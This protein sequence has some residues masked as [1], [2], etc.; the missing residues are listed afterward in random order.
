VS[1][2]TRDP[3]GAV[4]ALRGVDWQQTPESRAPVYDGR[5]VYE[6]RARLEIPAETLAVAAGNFSVSKISIRLF[7]R[8]RE[9]AGTNFTAWFANDAAR[10]P[11]L[12]LAELPLGSLRVEL[13]SAAQ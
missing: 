4:Y 7:Q 5:D 13:V 1:P 3:L 11:V 6:M 10:T 9:V 2:G 8:G 12:M